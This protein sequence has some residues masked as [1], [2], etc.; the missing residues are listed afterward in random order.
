MPSLQHKTFDRLL[1]LIRF[2]HAY[3]RQFDGVKTPRRS[4]PSAAE[5]KRR[6]I[7]QKEFEGFPFLWFDP[8]AGK[9]DG[10]V[11]ALHGGGYVAEASHGHLTS[12]AKLADLTGKRIYAPFYPLAPFHTPDAIREWTQHFVEHV[13]EHR[14]D[15]PLLM[16][17]DSAGANLALQL[18]QTGTPVERL[19][20]WSPWLDVEGANPDIL[21][22]DGA[23]A[24][25]RADGLQEFARTYYGDSDPRDPLLSPI[26]REAEDLPPTLILSGDQDLFHA[27]IAT[28]AAT[29][30][31]QGAPVTLETTPGVWHDFMLIP[32]PEARAALTRSAAFLCAS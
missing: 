12:Y 17:G 14:P 31:G 28:Y 1:R 26:F 29:R 18:I 16:T 9:P 27:D 13:R 23:C 22:R 5:R 24:L 30:A 20:L 21:A 32:T 7:G 8:K 6:P 15:A 19:V 10:Y 2:R 11:I 25:I 4:F 3:W